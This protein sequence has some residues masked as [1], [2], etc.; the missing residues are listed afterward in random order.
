MRCL[1]HFG[2]DWDG[3]VDYQ[4]AHLA[5]YQDI[6]RGLFN[7]NSLYACRCSRKDL[8]EFAVYPGRC[9]ALNFPDDAQSALRVRSDDRQ[10]N[11]DDALQGRISQNLARDHGDFVVRRRDGIIAYQFAVVVDDGRQGVNHVVRGADL[12]DSTP[13]QLYLQ[14][15]L[16]YP[17]PAYLHLPVIVDGNGQKLS[18]QTLAAPVNS[19]QPET[20]LWLILKLLEQNPPADLQRAPVAE[21]LQW[22]IVHWQSAALKKVRAIQP[23]IH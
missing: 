6:L 17:T 8:T 4:S 7:S 5:D 19:E 10:I 20:T 16:G 9:R 23:P 18:K 15:L 3:D 22:A 2:L 1:Q 21:Q 14:Q 13:K 12:L 11:F